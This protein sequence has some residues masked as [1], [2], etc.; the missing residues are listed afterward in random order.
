MHVMNRMDIASEKLIIPVARVWARQGL[1]LA[2]GSLEKQDYNIMTVGWGSFGVMWGKPFALV[3]VRPGRHTRQFMEKSADF[4]L[5]AF[6]EEHR[7]MLSYRRYGPV[8]I[9]RPFP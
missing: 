6:P 1:L 2:A 9:P 3:V 7:A 4:T 5:C 8:A